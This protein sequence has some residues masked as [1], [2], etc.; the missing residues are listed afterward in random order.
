MFGYVVANA[1][2]FTQEQRERY[3]AVYCGLCRA[4]GARSGQLARLSLT[5]DLSFLV[6]LLDSLEEPEQRSGANRC[7]THP[8]KPQS[9][10][11]SRWTDFAA[12]MNVALAYYKCLDDW[13]DDKNLTRLAFAKA[14]KT[15]YNQIQ[16]R[17]PE[18]CALI[19]CVLSELSA[20]EKADSADLDAAS[21]AFG[22]L[23]AGLFAAPGGFFVPQL[24]SMGDAL[25]RFIYVMDAVLDEEADRKRG[26]WNPAARFRAEQGGFE[27]LPT[28]ELL[29]GN[30][31]MAFEQ[32][33]LEQDLDL[34]RNVLYSGV[35]SQW[36]KKNRKNV[37][38]Q[39][40]R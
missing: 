33:P 12:D 17:W 32:L 35:W 8:I 30:C 37:D 15:A 5:Y 40:K 19:E 31:T 27:E 24:Q 21:A 39:E 34:L 38:R 28:L 20:L 10:R 6:L 11:S 26:R 3:R 14:L 1:A 2:Q 9:W 36:V 7:P 18:Q 4:I 29:M 25:G 13:Q 16:T 23:M 22:R